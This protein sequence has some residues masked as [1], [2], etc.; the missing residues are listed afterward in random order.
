MEMMFL[1]V[2][3]VNG[4]HE[5]T[6][7]F[8]GGEIRCGRCYGTEHTMM[9]PACAN[10]AHGSTRN[11]GEGLTREALQE[12]LT[13]Q[14]ERAGEPEKH[15]GFIGKDADGDADRRAQRQRATGGEKE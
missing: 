14:A 7:V 8:S 12:I 5:E 1:V 15:I 13:S 4:K 3:I 9:V 11:L 10:P 2:K 6:K